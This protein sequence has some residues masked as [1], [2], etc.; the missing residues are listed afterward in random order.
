MRAREAEA[1]G[2]GRRGF[3]HPYAFSWRLCTHGSVA[4]SFFFL[5]F[6]LIHP[7]QSNPNPNPISS[8]GFAP[9]PTL[10]FS[11]LSCLSTFPSNRTL[12]ESVFF[13]RMVGRLTSADPTLSSSN[14]PKA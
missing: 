6:P 2:G 11:L 3:E 7:I 13:F 4:F 1:Q 5:S 14:H 9:H 8:S 12:S 10:F